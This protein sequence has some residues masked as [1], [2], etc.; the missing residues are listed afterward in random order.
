MH[1]STWWQEA[2]VYQIY[3]RS[4]QDSNGDGIGDLPG[5]VSRLDYIKALGTDVVWVSPV[6]DSPNDDN[7]Y[8]IRDYRSIHPEFGTMDDMKRL[9]GELHR[10]DMRLVMDLVVNHCSDEHEWFR[11]ARS[12]RDS[13]YHDWFIWHPGRG[14]SEPT[15]PGERTPARPNNWGSFFSG[16]AWEWNE[17]TR[18]YYLHLFS[19]KQPDFNWENSDLRHAVYAMMRF[20]LDLGI[21]GFRMDVIN[22]IAKPDG[23]PDAPNPGKKKW[24]LAPE[25]VANL[26]RTH[27][28]LQEMNREVLAHYDCMTVGEMH[29][30]SV[31]EAAR[32]VGGG[33]HPEIDMIF[34]FEHLS[35]DNG[36][37][38]KYDI[39]REWSVVEL[40]RILARWQ[41]G[42]HGIGWNSLFTGNHDQPRIVSRYGNDGA[43]SSNTGE[44]DDR[45]RVRSASA[46]ATAFYL[47]EGTP[48]IYQGEEIG[49]T[50]VSFPSIEYYRDIEALNFYRGAISN[51][52][53]D[54]GNEDG[55]LL[56]ILHRRSRDNARTPVQWSN[57]PHGGFTT[58][59]PWI[60]VNPNFTAINVATELRREAGL[61]TFYRKL[62]RLRKEERVFLL[63]TYED[64]LP[65][66]R[67]I[68]AYARACDDGKALV[69]V[70]LSD[71]TSRLELDSEWYPILRSGRLSTCA[72]QPSGLPTSRDEEIR[73]TLEPWE[74]FVSMNRE[75][76][77]CIWTLN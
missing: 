45:A 37:K 28:H 38:G 21:D 67:T 47:M 39:P 44:W 61:L 76:E 63:G 12:S 32:Y 64:L 68:F 57:D 18:E 10:R 23:L 2:A 69:A 17:P 56:E 49:M 60:S 25:M 1:K 7:G 15:K 26:P 73:I 51:E 4:F 53:L 5:I 20:W 48:F 70:N 59:V 29:A 66:H 8:D 31:E 58:G 65:D 46:L 11:Q 19:R 71:K 77:N 22:F 16:S 6:Y 34:G 43:A 72:R 9:I 14:C 74:G 36:P 50:N 30:T 75:H 35:I 55:K 52:N 54:E 13:A 40:K 3:P 42:L 41:H 62:L 24:I 33:Q 27:E